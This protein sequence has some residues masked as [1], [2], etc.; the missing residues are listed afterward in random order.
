M[1]ATVSGARYLISSPSPAASQSPGSPSA[2]ASGRRDASTDNSL[3]ANPAAT[4]AS[5]APRKCSRSANE[6]TASRM[7][8][9]D[10]DALIGI[11]VASSAL[12]H[13]NV[14]IALPAP[15]P[16]RRLPPIPRAPMS[17]E[18][19]RDLDS[20]PIEGAVVTPPSGAASTPVMAQYHEIKRAHPGCL[21]F[22]RMGDF[23]ELF[24]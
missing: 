7:I 12:P 6:A 2:A 19:R 16:G 9:N 22:F 11:S 14:E 20:P 21:L 13:A 4:S 23:F 10:E 5:T 8:G 3:A 15:L 1:P 18:P 24:F 17:L